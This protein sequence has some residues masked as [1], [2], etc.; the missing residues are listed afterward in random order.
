M[1]D[2][3]R[4]E[5]LASY[6]AGLTAAQ[7]LAAGTL[8]VVM[9]TTAMWLGGRTRMG[10]FAGGATMEPILDQSFADADLRCITD[11]LN[12]RSVRHEVRDGKIYVPADR[13]LDA[14]SDLYYAAVLTGAGGS[15]ESGFDA[16]IKQMSAFDP[17]SKT[18]K[19]F[20]HA[21]E[22]T[23][24]RV[25]GRFRGVRKTTVVIDPTNERHISGSVLPSAMVDVQTQGESNARQLSSAAINVLT[26]CVAQ[27]SRDRVKVTVDG[28]T[29]NAGGGVDELVGTDELIARKQQCEQMYVGK[30][31]KL[32]SYIPDV[33][34]SVSV[35]LD[36]QSMEEE[37]HIVDPDHSVQRQA[38][39]ETPARDAA[40]TASASEGGVASAVG[41]LIANAVPSLAEG[42]E[43]SP[44][45]GGKTQEARETRAE[46]LP[47][48]SETVQKSR[49]PAGRETIRSASVVVPR[50]YFV[51]IYRRANRKPQLQ[52]PD[53]ALLQPVM[54]AHLVKIRGLV[55][56]ALGLASDE[57][58]T[59]EPYE[60]AAPIAAAPVAVAIPGVATATAMP[61]PAAAVL[62]ASAQQ[63]ALMA[64]GLVTLISLSLLLRRRPIV[65]GAAATAMPSPDRATVL[66]G[67]LETPASPAS[68]PA[69]IASADETAEAHRMFHRVRDVV[70]ENPDDAARVLRSWIYQG[71]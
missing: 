22:Q 52:E 15:T 36:V 6:F 5:W 30:V 56:N 31:R 69:P 18:D 53:D 23:C 64:L 4:F 48:T 55:K 14:L 45:A 42:S 44:N 28:A 33:M 19:L 38:R 2:R 8:V 60:D 27:L 9:I 41:S 43:A 51:G 20:N 25:I 32:L 54:D 11:H 16:L 24:E 29:Y 1:Q 59:V 70:G 46:Y 21:R 61:A 39:S 66:S 40:A 7:K 47:R 71:Q 34:V 26:G 49:T 50:S 58:V 57:D 37:R 10:G 17:P 3:K 13:K 65:A 63:I 62:N 35:D 68:P 67:T 12:A